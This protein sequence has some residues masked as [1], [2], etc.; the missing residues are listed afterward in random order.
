MRFTADQ[1]LCTTPCTTNPA[2]G[3]PGSQGAPGDSALGQADYGPGSDVQE[4]IEEVED[5]TPQ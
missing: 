2:P 4:G 5:N 1:R 3:Q